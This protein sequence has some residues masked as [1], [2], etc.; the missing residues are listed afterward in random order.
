[1]LRQLRSVSVLV[2]PSALALV[3]QACRGAATPGASVPGARVGAP[4]EAPDTRQILWQRELEPALALAR[5]EN[6]PLLL[7]VNMDGESASDRIVLENYRDPAFVA[8][9]RPFVCLVASVFRHNPRDYDEHGRRIP[10]PRLGECT[11]G[12]HLALEPQLFERFLSDGER[13]APRHALV[14]P[15]GG[16][17]WD[18]SLSF[19]LHDIDRALQASA[20]GERE[21]RGAQ[22]AELPCAVP[23]LDWAALAARRDA[24]GR[25]A[26]EERL[27]YAR[28]ETP[29]AHALEAIAAHGDAGAAAALRLVVARLA[30]L[31]PALRERFVACVHALGLE[32]VVAV[33]LRDRLRELDPLPGAADPA[34]ATLLSTLGPLNA[35]PGGSSGPADPGLHSMLLACSVLEGYRDEARSALG[36]AA[37]RALDGPLGR[38][39]GPLALSELLAMA[40]G[41]TRAEG[42]ALPRAAPARDALREVGELEDELAALELRL[43]S[44]P[45]PELLARFGKAALE[46]GRRRLESQQRDVQVLF[47]DAESNLR[48]ALEARPDETE[49]W[50]ERARAA[51]FL[52]RY[53]DEAEFGRR[54]LALATGTLLGTWS[55]EGVLAGDAR[56]RERWLGNE[57]AVEALRWI[58]DGDARLLAERSGKDPVLEAAGMLEGLRA[59]GLVAASPYGNAQDW[60]GFASF[61]GALGLW[62]EEFAIVRA[63]VERLPE[64]PELRTYLNNAL[65]N[66]GR[67]EQAPFLADAL[68]EARAELADGWWFA[69]RAWLLAGE[70]ARREELPERALHAYAEAQR[71]FERCSE[72]RADYAATCQ[73]QIAATWLGRGFAEARAGRRAGAARCLVNALEADAGLAR[74]A[75]GLGYEA[76]DLVDKTLEWTELGP[77]PVDALELAAELE[78]RTRPDPFWVL[79]ISDSELREALRADGR[80]P[81]RAMRDTVD[82]EGKPIR[83]LLGLPN[84]EGDAYLRASIAVARRAL[85]SASGAEDRKV[86][87]QADTIWAERQLERDRLAGVAEA[88]GEAATLLGLAPP[89]PGADAAALRASAAGLRELLGEARPRWRIGR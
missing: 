20:Q 16:K 83:M 67:F 76:L 50:L 7:A 37:A 21:R 85:S 13:V 17:A 57:P 5:A 22:A 41:V 28:G 3:A 49:W 4:A 52:A 31:S 8:A 79:A 36:P 64:A 82:A 73:N 59:L 1:M 47:D 74:G 60:L 10:C 33:Q 26:L 71:R 2:V 75:D 6:R 84:D 77:S 35:V 39:G 15:D 88:L 46:L 34:E 63:G 27:A 24:R 14:L 45:D 9:T 38:L 55:G 58:G 54:A 11:C 30:E 89:E 87:A 42:Q 69:G 44:E 32:H 72:R 23:E 62:R 18:L 29:L 25:R 86:I 78:E 12:E 81:V 48:R 53:A 43:R 61:A 70:Q 68:A 19:D 80:N 66:G 65:W 40:R 56:A 51:Y